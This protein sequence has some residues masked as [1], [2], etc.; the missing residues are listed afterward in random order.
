MEQT[1]KWY[2][3]KTIWG[4]II[5]ILSIVAGVAGYQIDP[6][7]QQELVNDFAGIGAIVGSLIAVYGRITANAKIK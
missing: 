6:S 4:S 2:Q 5:T 1:K 3:S 7:M